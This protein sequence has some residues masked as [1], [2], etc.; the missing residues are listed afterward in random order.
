M[1]CGTFN[2]LPALEQVRG[3]LKTPS[4]I[5]DET[6]AKIGS[7]VNLKTLT[8]HAKRSILDTLQ[9]SKCASEVDTAQF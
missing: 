6:F 5:D 1:N 9:S 4:N 3:V 2:E 8:Y 7:S